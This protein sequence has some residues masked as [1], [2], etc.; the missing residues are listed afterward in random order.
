[1][2]DLQR[3]DPDGNH[4]ETQV[5]NFDTNE[6]T[7][8]YLTSEEFLVNPLGVDFDPEQLVQRLKSGEDHASIKKR[9]ESGP[10]GLDSVPLVHD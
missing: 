3:R 7:N 5:D 8:A 6:E 1:M 4:I 9:P 2:A 10:R